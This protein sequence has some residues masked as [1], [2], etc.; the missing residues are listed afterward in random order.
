MMVMKITTPNP[1]TNPD[2]KIA[3]GTA[4]REVPII[5]FQME[6]LQRKTF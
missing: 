5:V 4:S 2:A 6:A 3:H 1:I